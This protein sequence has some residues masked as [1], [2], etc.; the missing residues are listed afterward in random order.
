MV[1]VGENSPFSFSTL[2]QLKKDTHNRKDITVSA[3][4]FSDNAESKQ[5]F[6][7]LFP[8]WNQYAIGLAYINPIVQNYK[9][10]YSPTIYVLNENNVIIKKKEPFE[11][12]Q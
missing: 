9:L 3:V 10:T 6:K 12:F 4:L 11:G 7:A 5:N 1:F 2:Q 8:D